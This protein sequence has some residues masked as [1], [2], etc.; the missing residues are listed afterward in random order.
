L[1]R[2]QVVA[3]EERWSRP[4]AAA[5]LLAVAGFIA[6]SLIAASISGDGEAAILRSAHEHSSDATLA[7]I[8]NAVAFLF[9]AAPLLYLFRVVNARAASMRSGMIVLLAAASLLLAASSGLGIAAKSN[10]VDMFI[11][12]EAKSTLTKGE[13]AKE[14]VA[15]LKDVGAKEFADEYPPAG[16]KT[17]RAVCEHEEIE[18]DEA[19]NAVSEASPASLATLFGITGALC[20]IVGLFY[21]A[22]WAMRTGVLSRFWAAFG[23]ALG[24]TVLIGIVLFLFVWLAY[25]G[26]L[27]GGWV[28]GGRPPA[29]DAGEA[30]PWPTPGEKAASDLAGGEAGSESSEAQPEDGTETRS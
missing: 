16:G 18:N 10:A 23:M 5:T 29:W 2:S 8:V 22:L 26:L 7:G 25:I 11:A 17:A 30:V 13:A 24:V 1:P 28:P 4:V 27:I 12:G 9:L 20:L 3:W 6:S 21:T 14:C 19:S 15:T